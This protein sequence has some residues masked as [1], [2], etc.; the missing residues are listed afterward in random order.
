M[1]WEGLTAFESDV[2]FH[3]MTGAVQSH[4]PG[5]GQHDPDPRQAVGIVEV[6]AE[7]LEKSTQLE[8]LCG[9]GCGLAVG[10]FLSPPL[11]SKAALQMLRKLQPPASVPLTH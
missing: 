8:A 7:R 2:D 1:N 9:M 4:R 10:Y 11:D 3:V 5:G 6:V